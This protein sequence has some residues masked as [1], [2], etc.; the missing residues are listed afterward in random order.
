MLFNSWIYIIFLVVTT[1]LY[2]RLPIRFRVPL[3]LVASY[4]FYM[5]WS[6]PFGIIYAPLIFI[7]SLYF[8]W[9]SRAMER[10]PNHKKKLLIFGV[11]TELALLAYFK[12]ANFLTSS[13]ENILK[14]IH[15]PAYHVEFSIFLPLAISFTNFVLISYLIDVYRGNEK[16]DPS[17][18]KFAAYI[19]FFP[20]LIAGPIVRAKELLHQFDQQLPFKMENLTKGAHLFL[21]G[22]FLKLFVADMLAPYVSLIY[23]TPDL[24][25]FDTSWVA[26]YSF[27][28]QIFCDFWGYTLMAQ[29]SALTMGYTLPDNFDA[30]YFSINITDFWRRW[31]MSLSRWLKDY[32]YIPLGGSRGGRFNTYRNLFLTMALGGL[33]HGA[34]WNF[35]I[36]GVYQGLLLSLHKFADFFK[37]NRLVPKF[38]AWFITFHLVCIGWVFFRA[39]R[40]EDSVQILSTMF[41]PASATGM[42]GSVNQIDI[43]LQRI[44]GEI[45]LIIVTLFLLCHWLF[46]RYQERFT[47][48]SLRDWALG[49]TYS[50]LLILGICLKT[51]PQE[52]IYFQF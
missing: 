40:F 34:S 49:L 37:I 22:L 4:T 21:S 50:I 52:F 47:N 3:I 28:I 31:H 5:S 1:I 6:P 39:A 32:L 29:G 38:V 27:A 46:R 15:C 33:W 7:D 14:M 8:Y 30:P 26:T 45:A 13:L 24:R 25:G 12:Y 11:T 23:G 18:V 9:L 35:I 44:N 20:H 48:I 51:N 2:W 19:A 10:W 42:L 36:W 43:Y 41:D 17:F 16:P